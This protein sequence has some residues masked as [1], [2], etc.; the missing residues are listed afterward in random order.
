MCRAHA[1]R[2]IFLDLSPAPSSPGPV[3]R[4]F[5]GNNYAMAPAGALSEKM[6]DVDPCSLKT[7][8]LGW[9]ITLNY[10]VKQN[11]SELLYQVC[12]KDCKRTLDTHIN[13][14]HLDLCHSVLV[15][16]L[17]CVLIVCCVCYVYMSM[18]VSMCLSF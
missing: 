3:P 2:C 12:D 14:L 11:V 15:H 10:N 18:C 13:V 7:L 16:V 4:Q 6:V 1:K 9:I 5:D 8:L 17:T